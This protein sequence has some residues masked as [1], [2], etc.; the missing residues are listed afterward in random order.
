[1]GFDNSKQSNVPT[2]L[3]IQ[4]EHL[5]LAE[6]LSG[7]QS[8]IAQ[9]EDKT[10]ELE[11]IT[12]V[13]SEAKKEVDRL[14]DATRLLEKQYSFIEEK[15]G[16]LQQQKT[17]LEAEIDEKNKEVAQK[18][19]D[20]KLLLAKEQSKISDLN[21][22]KEKIDSEEKRLQ[23]IIKKSEAELIS[24]AAIQKKIDEEIL[25][26]NET[27]AKNNNI[28][29]TLDSEIV[30]KSKQLSDIKGALENLKLK[31][32]VEQNNID[33]AIKNNAIIILEA[34]EKA[35]KIVYDAKNEYESRL[36]KLVI[37]E[38]QSSVKESSLE[39]KEKKLRV[40]VSELEKI[41][42]KKIPVQI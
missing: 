7:F 34:Q 13:I 21:L 36:N 9:M 17:R 37:Q 18:N 26:F 22:V 20:I 15:N 16:I 33:L 31:I 41:H 30:I 27:S 24:V 1:M 42:G 5:R 2:N 19:E 40:V 32:S 28:L 6:E 29:S 8:Q 10:G 38:G 12:L 14:F 39:D 25:I 11:K 3:E 23:E 4:K 35:K